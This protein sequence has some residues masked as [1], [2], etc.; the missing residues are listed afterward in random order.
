MFF[1][2]SDSRP[3]WNGKKKNFHDFSNIPTEFRSIYFRAVT[4]YPLGRVHVFGS[5]NDSSS[6]RK[7]KLPKIVFTYI[8]SYLCI[9]QI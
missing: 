6:I 5:F 4:H 1:H 7:L 2:L 8:S 9:L 3:K